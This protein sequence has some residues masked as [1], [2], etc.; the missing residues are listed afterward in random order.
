MLISDWSSDVCSSDL[1]VV[2]WLELMPRWAFPSPWQVVKAFYELILNGVLLE[3]TFWSVLRQLTGVVLATL[4]GVPVGLVLGA[5]RTVRAAFLPLFRMVYPIPG[6]AWI[7]LAILW[8]GIGFESTVF[9]L[10]FTG[11]WPI[12]FHT[13]DGVQTLSGQYKIDRAP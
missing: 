4:F 3:N 11:I 5:S 10:F 9:V 7:P 6:I 2:F 13:M 8:F 1:Q 12:I